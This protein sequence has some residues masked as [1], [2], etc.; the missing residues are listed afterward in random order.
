MTTRIG[1]LKI[2]TDVMKYMWTILHDEKGRELGGLMSMELRNNKYIINDIQGSF[3]PNTSF[4]VNIPKSPTPKYPISF[5]THPTM[6]YRKSGLIISPPSLRDYKAVMI[7]LLKGDIAHFLFTLEGVYVFRM[8][9]RVL[10]FL[11]RM[12]RSDMYS[13]ENIANDFARQ[14]EKS[15]GPIL[16]EVCSVVYQISKKFGIEYITTTH[17]PVQATQYKS[18]NGLHNNASFILENIPNSYMKFLKAKMKKLYRDTV[19]AVS[20]MFVELFIDESRVPRTLKKTQIIH[21]RLYRRSTPQDDL[22]VLTSDYSKPIELSISI[23][24]TVRNAVSRVPTE[25]FRRFSASPVKSPREPWLML[26]TSPYSK[27]KLRNEYSPMNVDRRKRTRP[28]ST[29]TGNRSSKRT[30][31]S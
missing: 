2:P 12:I 11:K 30:K 5:H 9:N 15:I 28:R 4:N 17:I 18:K 25:R 24:K 31:R 20:S 6:G 13:I 22:T 8:N 19:N 21:M 16:N 26:N 29:N 1:T 7:R 27:T 10:R 23:P 14:V 3:G